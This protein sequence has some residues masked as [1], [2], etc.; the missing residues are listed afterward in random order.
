[1]PVIRSAT[2]ADDPAVAAIARA[3]GRPGTGSGA[4]P[5]HTGHLRRHGTLL[6]AEHDGAVAGF[7]AT[8]GVGGAS[9]LTDLFVAP[10]RRGGGIGGALLG[11]L[12][13]A[14][15]DAPR[16]YTFASQDPRALALYLRAGLTPWW[17]LLYLRGR[18]AALPGS[19]L[20]V[21]R[22]PPHEAARAETRLTGIDRAADL[23]SAAGIGLVVTRDG[24]PVAAG[25]A[26][27]GTA[28]GGTHLV[29]LACPNPAVAA[30]ALG[31]VLHALGDGEVALCLPGPHPALPG[32][33]AAGYRIVGFDVHLSTRPGLLPT[34]WVYSPGLG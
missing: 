11:A 19:S 25:A 2:A 13:P 15:E 3:N 7:G 10:A 9:L 12:W 28:T 16:R 27:D 4:D 31:A 6:V 26:T 1:M 17:P 23:A 32:L 30:D 21:T 22:C 8:L 5:A 24:R 20:G 29:H 34:S 18:P 33:L 14:G